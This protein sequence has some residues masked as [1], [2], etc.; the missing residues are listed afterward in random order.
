M[1]ETIMHDGQQVSVDALEK[2]AKQF[3][4]PIADAELRDIKNPITGQ[5]ELWW[6]VPNNPTK[7]AV[8]I[9]KSAGRTLKTVMLPVSKLNYTSFITGR[10]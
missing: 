6:Y 5:S 8:A 1:K 9:A 10:A 4:A 3:G 2:A 7:L